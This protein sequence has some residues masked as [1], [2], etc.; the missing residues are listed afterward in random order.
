MHL[1]Q[2]PSPPPAKREVFSTIFHLHKKM[3]SLHSKHTV[4]E[5]NQYGAWEKGAAYDSRR[6]A[7]SNFLDAFSSG[8]K[9]NRF[10]H[11]TR[12]P[13]HLAEVVLL[14]DN[15]VPGTRLWAYIWVMNAGCISHSHQIRHGAPTARYRH[16]HGS[17]SSLPVLRNTQGGFSLF[18]FFL[19]AVS[20][21]FCF[22]LGQ[23]FLRACVC[24]VFCF[25]FFVCFKHSTETQQEII[26]QL[27]AANH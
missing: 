15:M 16:L 1:E 18:C 21:V 23:L 27:N 7:S 17:C 24:V 25:D 12:D 22:T 14:K 8:L 11:L 10:H 20:A 6:S 5:G 4:K 26:N 19:V 9:E 13:S 3:L 2:S